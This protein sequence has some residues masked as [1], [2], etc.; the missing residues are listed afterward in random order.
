MCR[1]RSATACCATSTIMCSTT[2][3]AAWGLQPIVRTGAVRTRARRLW[4]QRA[5]SRPCARSCARRPCPLSLR[6]PAP[7]GRLRLMQLVSPA[8]PIGAFTYS[9]GLE[10]AV[11]AGWV[12][13]TATLER[14][15]G[16]PDGRQPGAARAADPAAPVRG[17]RARRSPMRSTRWGEQLYASRETRELR[18][19]ER[20]R[21]RALITL[22]ADLEIPQAADWREQ[23]IALPG[24]ALRAGRG[25]L[26]DRHRGL[27]ARLCLGLAGKPGRRRDQAGARW[28]RPTV[29]G[30]SCDWP[31]RLPAI[32]ERALDDRR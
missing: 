24:R 14:L 27:P 23:L 16:G 15:A 20:N 18:A 31:E 13:D 7:L 17:L 2:C 26:A 32:V 5:G 21:A 19:E 10:W 29:S 12:R 1:C 30:C 11:E 6:R 4:R 22:L 25:A 8:L 9:Q 3:C 28:A